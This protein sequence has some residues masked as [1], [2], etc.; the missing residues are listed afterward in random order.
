MT[1]AP[2]AVRSMF[3]RIAPVYDAMNRVMT[4]G[5]D[6]RWRRLA[7]SEVVRPGDRVLDAACGTGDFAVADHRAGAR[8]GDGARLLAADAGARAAQGAGPASASR[9][10]CSPC[11]STTAPSTPRPSASAFGTS[12]TSSWRCASSDASCGPAGGS[13]SSRS[14]SRAGLLRPFFALWFDRLVPAARPAASGRLRVLVPAGLGRAGSRA[15]RSSRRCSSG[16]GS[17]R[18]GSGCWRVRSSPCTL[19][20]AG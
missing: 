4:A 1:L 7:A 18:C 6:L 11:R 17:P 3:D 9:A 20:E 14:R 5:L 2:E 10:T 16:P 12:P 13:R 8:R 19:G 15:P